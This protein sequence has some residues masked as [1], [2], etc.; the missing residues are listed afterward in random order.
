MYITDVHSIGLET[1]QGVMLSEM[2]Y[3]DSNDRTRAF[4]ERVRPKMNGTAPNQEQAGGY[5]AC[6]TI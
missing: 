3:W 4:A 6:S 1:A 5:S 2:F